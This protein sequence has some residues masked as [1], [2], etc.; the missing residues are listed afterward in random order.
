MTFLYSCP[1][2]DHEQEVGVIPGTPAKTWGPPEFCD[3]GSDHEVDFGGACEVCGY[4]FD[5]SKLFEKADDIVKDRADNY[6][7]D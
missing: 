2:C 1:Q 3:P 6:N 7:E 4:E 5:E